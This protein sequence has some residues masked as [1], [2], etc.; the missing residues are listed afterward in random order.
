MLPAD[1]IIRAGVRWLRLLRASTFE[2]AW[3]VILADPGY[4]DLTQTQYC[5]ALEWL[6]SLDLLNEG[7]KGELD[8]SS[9][10]RGLPEEEANQLLFEGMI[11][12]AAPPWLANADLLVPDGGE[13]PQDAASLAE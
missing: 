8:L 6:R 9:T 1:S 11:A 3:G 7:F 2:K 5:S 10:I 4:T 13:L 12:R